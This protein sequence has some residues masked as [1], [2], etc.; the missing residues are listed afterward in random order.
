VASITS[1]EFNHDVGRAKRA[2]KVEPVIITDRGEPAFVLLTYD[3]FERMRPKRTLLDIF[4]MDEDIE[5]EFDPQPSRALPRPF[6]FD[7]E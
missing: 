6:E 4:R 2:A 5:I 7:D 3:D 1:R